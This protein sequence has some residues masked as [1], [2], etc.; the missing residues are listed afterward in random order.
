MLWSDRLHV[1]NDKILNKVTTE[2]KINNATIIPGP[3]TN[4][5]VKYVTIT[6]PVLK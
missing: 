2:C 6:I 4:R 1:T 3:L 5:V